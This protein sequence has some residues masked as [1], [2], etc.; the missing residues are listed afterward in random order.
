MRNMRFEKFKRELEERWQTEAATQEAA[1][2]RRLEQQKQAFEVLVQIA[3]EILGH[4]EW[5]KQNPDCEFAEAVRIGIERMDQNLNEMIYQ[6]CEQF[7]IPLS[8]ID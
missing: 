2:Q 4:N 8:V 7:D 1:A 5:L 3:E 6:F